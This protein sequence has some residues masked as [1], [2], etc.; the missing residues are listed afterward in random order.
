MQT[1]RKEDEIDIGNT[2]AEQI[3]E[4]AKQSAQI[5]LALAEYIR[6]DIAEIKA[7]AKKHHI[8]D[9]KLILLVLK[10]IEEGLV[11]Y[12]KIKIETIAK[13]LKIA[14]DELEKYLPFRT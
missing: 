10:G 14:K 11:Q 8:S 4:V 13:L 9:S 1:D 12:G 2:I 6:R 3:E 7:Y 5:D